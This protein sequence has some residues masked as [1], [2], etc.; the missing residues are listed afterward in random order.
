VVAHNLFNAFF[1]ATLKIKEDSI[2]KPADLIK[3]MTKEELKEYF[4]REWNK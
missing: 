3:N 2:E 4:N 1:H